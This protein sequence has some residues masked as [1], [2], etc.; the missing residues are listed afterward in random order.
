MNKLAVAALRLAAQRQ[1]ESV[2]E[3]AALEATKETF[4]Y[5]ARLIFT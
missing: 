5:S 3:A 4:S 2:D 1:T